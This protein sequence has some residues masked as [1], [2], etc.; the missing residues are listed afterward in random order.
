[1]STIC[2][3]IM[4]YYMKKC[5]FVLC[6]LVD[7]NEGSLTN[8]NDQSCKTYKRFLC[9]MEPHHS[10]LL[11]TSKICTLLKSIHDSQSHIETISYDNPFKLSLLIYKPCK[12]L[13]DRYCP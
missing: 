13:S 12:L 8:T 5:C 6:I 9:K 10:Q 1:M 2:D 11:N 4:W 7:C 3:N